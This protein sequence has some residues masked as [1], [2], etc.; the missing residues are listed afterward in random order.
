MRHEGFPHPPSLSSLN[1]FVSACLS[2]ILKHL[3]IGMNM[4]T[5][6]CAHTYV[7]THVCIHVYTYKHMMMIAFIITFGEIM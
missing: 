6:T 2:L 3:Y 7:Y 4:Y 5:Y 1:T